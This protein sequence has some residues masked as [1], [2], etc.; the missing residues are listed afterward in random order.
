[1]KRFTAVSS[2]VAAATLVSA[3]ALMGASGA[4]ASEP[5]RLN[6]AQVDTVPA[7][8]G[9]ESV[10]IS[11]STTTVVEGGKV[12]TVR[13]R[14]II[15]DGKKWVEREVTEEPFDAKRHRPHV[16]RRD[17]PNFQEDIDAFRSHA[18]SRVAELRQRAAAFRERAHRR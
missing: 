18:E 3:T 11:Q 6:A 7:G 14:T 5:L 4:G 16:Q 8:N 15:R 13:E 2:A 10:G 1:M 17:N 12:R 9:S